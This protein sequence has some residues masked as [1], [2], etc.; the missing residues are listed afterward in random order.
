MSEITIDLSKL[1]DD[2]LNALA[3]IN[4]EAV[5]EEKENRSTYTAEDIKKG[6]IFADLDKVYKILKPVYD[7]SRTTDLKKAITESDLLPVLEK[8][9]R[10]A[11]K[12]NTTYTPYEPTPVTV[13]EEPTWTTQDIVEEPVVVAQPEPVITPMVA[14]PEP[15]VAEPEPVITPMVAPT[16]VMNPVESASQEELNKILASIPT[17]GNL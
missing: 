2:Q 12:N 6:Q 4:P 17:V 7:N 5:K 11:K 3:I 14:Q 16:P 8:V 10:W 9:F 1:S 13:I 15:V